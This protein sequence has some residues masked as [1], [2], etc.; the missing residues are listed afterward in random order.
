ME[1]ALLFESIRQGNV[2]SFE[3]LFKSYY[4]KLVAFANSYVH[5]IDKSESITQEIFVNLWEHRNRYEIASIKNYLYT[6][7]RNRCHNELKRRAYD[8]KYQSYLHANTDAFYMQFSDERLLK[9]IHKV[10]DELPEQ[11]KKIFRLNRIDG[12]KYKE[13]AVQ[14]NISIKTVENQMSKALKYL[15]IHLLELKKEVY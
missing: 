3:K 10:I 6:A 5:D 7:I 12:L 11:R 2:N 15:R 14:L 8:N 13:I 9:Y 1:D 4:P